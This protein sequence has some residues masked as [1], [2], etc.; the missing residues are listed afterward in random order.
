[1]VSGAGTLGGNR[2]DLW[3]VCG[4]NRILV[5]KV[6]LVGRDDDIDLAVQ[7]DV[8]VLARVSV[9]ANDVVLGVK[10]ELHLL[11]DEF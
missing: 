9:V 10:L 6:H 5:R 11:A 2:L 1:M 3:F 8:E 4:Y 7:D